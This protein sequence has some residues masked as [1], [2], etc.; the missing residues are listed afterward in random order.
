MLRII[1]LSC[2]LLLAPG[3]AL[4]QK[5][6]I[7]SS[8]AFDLPIANIAGKSIEALVG[9]NRLEQI[10]HQGEYL[11]EKPGARHTIVETASKTESAS[12]HLCAEY[13]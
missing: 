7:N 2:A 4:A 6:S 8:A 5:S 13:G 12:G 1:S 3:T 11:T 10:Y 9:D